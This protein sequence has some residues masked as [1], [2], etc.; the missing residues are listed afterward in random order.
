MPTSYHWR[1][2]VIQMHGHQPEKPNQVLNHPASNIEEKI[3]STI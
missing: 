1:V 3:K 2:S